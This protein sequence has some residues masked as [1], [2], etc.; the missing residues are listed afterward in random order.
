MGDVRRIEVIQTN[1]LLCF[2]LGLFFRAGQKRIQ[3][4]FCKIQIEFDV[5]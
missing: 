5:Y 4:S 2:F 3:F 1:I